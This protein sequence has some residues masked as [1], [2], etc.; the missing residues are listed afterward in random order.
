MAI[1]ELIIDI[2]ANMARFQK[3]IEAVKRQSG[4]LQKSLDG[5]FSGIQKSIDNA[6]MALKTLAGATA[7]TVIAKQTLDAALAMEKM[8]A[9]IKATA[10]SSV[11]ASRNMAFVRDISAK[12]GL[13]VKST[14][15]AFAKFTAS[16]RNTSIEGAETKRIFTSVAEAATAMRLPAEQVNG[17]FLALGQMMSKGKVSAEELN[18]QL[19]ERLPGALKLAA[20]GMGMTTA[21]LM[22]QMQEGKI[23]SADLLP[24]LADQLHKTYGVAAKEGAEGGQ[25]AINKFNNSL[26]EFKAA[27]GSAFI[28]AMTDMLN[29][30]TPIIDRFK[31]ILV[32]LHETKIGMQWAVGM[33]SAVGNGGPLGMNWLTSSGRAGIKAEM[34]AQDALTNYS[35]KKLYEKYYPAPV[36]GA[37]SAEL[38]A[39]AAR[40]A[41][42]RAAE[43]AS[44][45]SAGKVREFAG[46]KMTYAE[47]EM[48]K[49]LEE[50]VKRSNELYANFTETALAID[51]ISAKLG[52]FSGANNRSGG[53]P[54][55]L[56]AFDLFPEQQPYSTT[57]GSGTDYRALQDQ[58][59]SRQFAADNDRTGYEQQ[60]L[61]IEQWAAQW[62][63]AWA[64]NTSSFEVYNERMVAIQEEA[65]KRM[66]ALDRATMNSRLEA[67]SQLMGDIASVLMQGNRKA[68]DIGKGF[69]IAQTVID[70]YVGAQKAYISMVG[71]PYVGPVLAGVAAAT[72][73][74]GGMMRIAAIESTKYQPRAMGGP[75][76]GGNAYLVGE[77]GPEIIRMGANGF[78]TPNHMIPKGGGGTQVTNVFQVSTGVSETVRAEIMRMAPGL[79]AMSVQAVEQAINSGTSLS[80]AVGRM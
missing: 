16:T 32:Y 51:D 39:E 73:I 1:G 56:G 55:V 70:T 30:T 31:S 61:Y 54:S 15:E 21:A 24:K 2:A 48:V 33:A 6:S 71:I 36:A 46:T 72:A 13:E 59:M 76:Y 10:S 57:G 37:S 40:N 68:F 42:R 67:T 20:D 45:A 26:F 34:D 11:D 28:P 9:Q 75:V 22:K 5:H 23:M 69:A 53:K 18:G 77:Q 27:V 47:E 8:Q 80:R 64:E 58:A 52:T 50:A 65:Q 19:G 38:S 25:A 74:A 78:V 35:L 14:A 7:I 62:E 12:L 29:A 3:D 66:Q 41:Q 63:T 4:D 60:R 49:W 43:A 17:V 79:A 44:T